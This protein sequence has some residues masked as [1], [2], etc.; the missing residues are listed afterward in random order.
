[1]TN[2]RTYTALVRAATAPSTTTMSASLDNGWSVGWIRGG[3]PGEYLVILT[4]Q[5]GDERAALETT[6]GTLGLRDL[7]AQLDATYNLA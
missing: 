4:D 1:M 6:R 5:Y 3:M 7:F 2:A